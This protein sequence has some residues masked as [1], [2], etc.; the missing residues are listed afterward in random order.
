MAGGGKGSETCI[1]GGAKYKREG[2]DDRE[3]GKRMGGEGRRI[4]WRRKKK[5]LERTG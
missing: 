2:D 3:G 5:S 1:D 4:T